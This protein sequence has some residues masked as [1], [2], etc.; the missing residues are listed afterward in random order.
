MN[1]SSRPTS[2]A[3]SAHGT[4]LAFC[5]FLVGFG[6]FFRVVR[7]EFFPEL[8]NFAPLMAIACCGALLLPG[9][10]ALAAPLGALIVSDILLNL[11]YHASVFSLEELPR[12]FCFALGVAS[13]L[14]ARRFRGAPLPVLGTVAANSIFF[15]LFTNTF[16]WLGNAAYPK[17]AAGLLQALTVGVPGWPPTWTFLRNSL[18][19]DLIFAGVFLVALHFSTRTQRPE[20]ALARA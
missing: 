17:T 1:I 6:A 20:T 5:L 15:Y 4:T 3:P 16:S 11:H 7:L 8:Q 13:G 19:S 12:Y 18:A 10:L 2:P 14:F 9:W